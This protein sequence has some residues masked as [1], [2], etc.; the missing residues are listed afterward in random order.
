MNSLPARIAIALVF[1]IV[2][3]AL[4]QKGADLKPPEPGYLYPPGGRAGSTVDVQVAGFDWTPDLQFFVSDPRVKLE[5]TGAMGPILVPPPPYW[6]GEKSR[7]APLPLPREQPARLTLPADLP[8]GPIR[9]SVASANGVGLRT[10]IIWVGT[11][12]EAIED[13]KRTGPQKLATLPVTVNGRLS[14]IEEVD[15]YTFTALRDGPVTCVLVARRLGVDM[16]AALSIR[17]ARGNLV[18]D[19]VDTQGRDLELTFTASA[20]A[21]YTV[22][23]NDLDFRGDRSFVYRLTLTAGP[24]ITATIPAVGKRGETR[25]VEFVGVGLATGKPQVESVTREVT[26][27]K[28]GGSFDH[29][30]ETAWGTTPAFS[31]PLSDRVE[32]VVGAETALPAN[33]TGAFDKGTEARFRLDAKKGETWDL[34]AEARRFGSPADVSLTVLAADGKELVRIDDLPGTTD[35]GL[36]FTPTVDGTYTV[37]VA[38]H[39]GVPPSRALVYRFTAERAAADF[40]L[41]TVARLNVRLGATADLVVAVKRNGGYKEP[42]A[43]KVSGLPKG[44]TVPE[45]LVIPAKAANLKVTFTAAADA[46]VVAVKVKVTGSAGAGAEAKTRTALAPLVGNQSP[47]GPEFEQTDEVLLAPTL[48]P[49]IKVIAVE[50]DGGRKVHRG[51]THPAEVVIERVDGF[52]GDVILQP[53]ATQ[54]YQRQ[55]IDGPDLVV[56]PAETRVFYPV[57]MP[58]WLETTRTSR[59][60]LVGV[61][62]VTDPAGKTRHLLTPMSGQI[63]MSIEGSLLKVAHEDR[64]YRAK[65][66][67]SV[68]VPLTVLRATKLAQPVRLELVSDD[69]SAGLFSAEPVTLPVGKTRAD[70]RITLAADAKAVGERKAI[71]RGVALQDG[72]YRVVSQTAVTI[73]CGK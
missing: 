68:T 23:L 66:G 9:W 55:G 67:E 61:I 46:E 40:T 41:T 42:I 50:A 3:S 52:T 45:N 17:D 11:G 33:V 59:M 12:P 39:S 47:R 26:F 1:A 15:D 8:A 71:I 38:D 53:A 36:A 2:P 64:E 10:G 5:T 18:A 22:S 49:R 31:I 72:R 48:P 43:L 28:D 62:R 63:T 73:D 51:S 16:N 65:A 69:D 21:E 7:L 6:F 32:G 4:A 54:S 20:G 58:E 44:I 29:A 35:A 37:V 19:A 60:A 70:F 57:F 13:A 56:P 27:P 24:R 30:L 14:R 34:A 25:S